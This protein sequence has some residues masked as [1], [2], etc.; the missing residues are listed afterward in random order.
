M[1]QG[2]HAR[3]KTQTGVENLGVAPPLR[4]RIVEEDHPIREG[5]RTRRPSE[6]R[7][8]PQQLAHTKKA[9]SI[10]DRRHVAASNRNRRALRQHARDLPPMGSNHRPRTWVHGVFVI[11]I[12]KHHTGEVLPIDQANRLDR[13]GDLGGDQ[14]R[15]TTG[16]LEL[17]HRRDPVIETPAVERLQLAQAVLLGSV[18]IPKLAIIEEDLV[19]TGVQAQ[20]DHPLAERL[21]E[22]GVLRL[23]LLPTTGDRGDLPFDRERFKLAVDGDRET[24]G[25]EENPSG[26]LL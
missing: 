26:R 7:A 16:L 14:I 12:E 11:A 1:G 4:R 21:L 10:E 6:D 2:D 22:L 23:A 13:R 20:I 5:H 18:G 19:A 17:T 9:Q 8:P 24:L 25:A 3:K 15:G